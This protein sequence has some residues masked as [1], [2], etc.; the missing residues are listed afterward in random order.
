M[1]SLESYK[2]KEEDRV[3]DTICV[4]RQMRCAGQLAESHDINPQEVLRD[5]ELLAKAPA[6]Y[7]VHLLEKAQSHQMLQEWEEV[8]KDMGEKYKRFPMIRR[9]PFGLPLQDVQTKLR[10]MTFQE[11]ERMTEFFIENNGL[12]KIAFEEMQ[13]DKLGILAPLSTDVLTAF[14]LPEYIRRHFSERIPTVKPALVFTGLTNVILPKDASGRPVLMEMNRV[15]AFVDLDAM[16]DTKETL[17][18]FAEVDYPGKVIKPGYDRVKLLR[19]AYPNLNNP[20]L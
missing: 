2:E 3:W 14:L 4:L 15:L 10:V 16:G 1:L 6:P 13:D 9:S 20:S 17:A 12:G 18:R 11:P 8:L 5:A 19:R 7:L